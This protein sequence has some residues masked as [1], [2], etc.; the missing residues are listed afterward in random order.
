MC[1]TAST[2][3]KFREG[4]CG[5]SSRFFVGLDLTADRRSGDGHPFSAIKDQEEDLNPQDCMTRF[6]N[7]DQ[8]L[9]RPCPAADDLVIFFADSGLK[10][11][12]HLM[13]SPQAMIGYAST[14]DFIS[15]GTTFMRSHCFLLDYSNGKV[16]V[17]EKKVSS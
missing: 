12:C 11:R 13:L 6:R 5:R 2:S 7:Q 15:L 4:K 16:A 17:A 3:K 14:S 8:D 10:D 1:G 9:A